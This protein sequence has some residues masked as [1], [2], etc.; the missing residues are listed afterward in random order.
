MFSPRLKKGLNWT[1][2][3]G[4]GMLPRDGSPRRG[5][6]VV[7]DRGN[8]KQIERTKSRGDAGRLRTDSKSGEGVQVSG[9]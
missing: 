6:N 9:R 7:G 4:D 5:N 2:V 8:N 3:V 1:E